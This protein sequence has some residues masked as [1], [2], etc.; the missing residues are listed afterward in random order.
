M[1]I[2][3]FLLGRLIALVVTLLLASLAVY[4]ALYLAPGSPI[5]FL[6][7]GRTTSPEELEAIKAQYHLDEGFLGQYTHWISGILHGDFGTSILGKAPVLSLLGGRAYNTLLLVVFAAVI[8]LIVGLAVG[9]TAG[10]KPGW[11]DKSLMVG[12]TGAMAV[13]AFVAAIVLVLI[14]AVN[15]QWFP[16]FG[17]GDGGLADH[18]YHLVL[19][20]IALAFASVAYVARLTRAAVRTEADSDHVQTAVS[21]GLPRS[22]VISRH[23]LRNAMI[24]I[25]TVAGLTIGG[26]IAGAVV[27]EQVFQLN[28]LGSF[29]VQAVGQKDF[30]VVQAIV[31]ILVAVFIVL[32]TV[33]DVLYALLDP[34]ITAGRQSA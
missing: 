20:S 11:I 23:V 27:I 24:P 29:L 19:P 18:L 17:T 26:L 9:I 2:A 16:V 13:P 8:I 21:R 14:F 30:P 15:L 4:G 7:R 33:V 22:A 6:T 32:N 1:T 10:L 28:G 12:A 31:L 25:V 34:R 5:A 3:R